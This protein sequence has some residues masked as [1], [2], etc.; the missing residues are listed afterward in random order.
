MQETQIGKYKILD[1][2]GRGGMGIVYKGKHQELNM[3]VAIKTLP[4]ELTHDQEYSKRHF[5]LLSVATFVPHHRGLH[6]PI[7]VSGW[8]PSHE[9]HAE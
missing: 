3:P 2:I 6:R 1:E 4:I 7:S 5:G 9:Y 8:H